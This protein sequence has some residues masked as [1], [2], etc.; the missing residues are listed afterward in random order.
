M[1]SIDVGSLLVAC[2]S[3]LPPCLVRGGYIVSG[4]DTEV[5]DFLSPTRRVDDVV[6]HLH[7]PLWPR[8]ISVCWA[9]C[10]PLLTAARSLRP[11]AAS[12]EATRSASFS[13]SSPLCSTSPSDSVMRT[14]AVVSPAALSTEATLE[15]EVEVDNEAE[16]D[17]EEE[18]DEANV[19]DAEG[20]REA[21][22]EEEEEEMREVVVMVVAGEGAGPGVSASSSD[23]CTMGS[24]GGAY[25]R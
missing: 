5:F 4:V 1:T 23:C 20:T 6:Y 16:V 14:P 12:T 3:G 7:R 18:D 8:Q 11:V 13:F 17:E 2:E 15:A 25:L 19:E 24:I 21:E 10:H 22:G 9:L